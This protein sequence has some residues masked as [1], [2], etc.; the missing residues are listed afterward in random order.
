MTHKKGF[1]CAI[2]TI[3]LLIAVYILCAKNTNKKVANLDSETLKSMTYTEITDDDAKIDNCEFVEFS[4]FFT[5]DLNGDGK[6]E[7][8]NGVCQNIDSSATVYFRLSV[9]SKGYLKNGKISIDGKNFRLDTAIAADDVIAENYIDYDTKQ[10]NFVDKV[11]NGTQKLIESKIK[12]RIENINDYSKSDNSVIF[13]GTYVYQDSNGSDVEIPISKKCNLTVDWYGSLSSSIVTK[14]VIKY[15]NDKIVTNENGNIDLKFTVKTEE[16]SYNRLLLNSN[17]VTVNIPKIK[18]ISASNAI[19][20]NENVSTNYDI[21]SGKLVITRKAVVDENGNITKALPSSNEYEIKMTY[22]GEI[23]NNSA[24]ESIVI[25][26]P[27]QSYYTGF[28]N[29]GEEFKNEI[30]NNIAKSNV[31]EK[32]FAIT[33]ENPIGE[34]YEFDTEVGEYVTYPYDRYVVSKKETMK[35]YNNISP[36]QND[37]YDVRWIFKRGTSGVIKK[38][39]MYATKAD[40]LNSNNS[41]EDYTTN[42]GIYIDGAKSMLNSDGYINIYDAD[43]SGNEALLHS[44]T[45][46]DWDKYT[47]DAP[48]YYEKSVK[49]IRAEISESNQ[50]STLIIHNVKQF[51]NEKLAQKYS[52]QE[53]ESLNL[54]YTNLTGVPYDEN[55]VKLDAETRTEV[56]YYEDEISKARATISRDKISTVET[57]ENEII[58][59][60]TISENYNESKWKNGEFLIEMPT[61]ITLMT[62]NSVKS[63][64]SKVV[65]KGYNLFEK[66]GKYF[67]KI[68]TE[69][70]VPDVYEVYVDC[71]ITPNS[72]LATVTKEL[73]LYA[74]NEYY[75]NYENETKDI[76]DANNNENVEELVGISSDEIQFVAPTGLITYQS[77]TDYNEYGDVTTAPNVAEIAKE[78]RTATVIINTIN[79][80]SNTISSTKI[81]GKIPFEGNKY[82]ITNGNLGS[83]YTANLNSKIVLDLAENNSTE[84]SDEKINE[85]KNNI[86]IYYST[87]EVTNNNLQDSSNGWTLESDVKD[88]SSVKTYLIDFGNFVMDK[89]DVISFKYEIFVPEGIAYEKTTYSAYAVYFNL[90]TPDGKLADYTEPNKLGIK[91]TRKYNLT[92]T[93]NKLGTSKAVQ[94]AL[95][96]LEYGNKNDVNYESRI[97]LTD[98]NGQINFENLDV[99]KTYKLSELKCT[100][101]YE[102]S[103]GVFEFKVVEN[104]QNGKLELSALSDGAGYNS[105]SINAN[106]VNINVQDKIKFKL[107]LTKFRLGTSTKVAGASYIIKSEIGDEELNKTTNS[108]GS[109]DIS[110]LTLDKTYIIEEISASDNFALAQGNLKFVVSQSAE[111]GELSVKILESGA[112]YKTYTINQ[113]DEK[114]SIQLE[115]EIRYKIV[116]NKKDSNSNANLVGVKYQ[117]KGKNVDTSALTDENGNIEFSKLDLGE[118]YIVT[119]VSAKDYYINEPFEVSVTKDV[120]GNLKSNIGTITDN[121]TE[122]VLNINATDTKIPTY[123]LT[124]VKVER[125]NKNKKLSGVTFVVKG[126]NLNEEVT[127]NEEGKVTINGLYEHISEKN[128][129]GTYIIQEKVTADGYILTSDIL[130]I[131]VNRSDN[132][133][134]A[135]ILEGENLISDADNGKD[136]V[137]DNNEITL[138]LENIPTFKVKK[139]DSET[140]NPIA[141]TK[142]AIYKINY[143]DDGTQ[144][145]VEEA[146]DGNGNVIGDE[147]TINNIKYHIIKTNDLGEAT[148]NLPAGYYYIEEIETAEGY[149]LPEGN[150]KIHYFGIGESKQKRA[151]FTTDETEKFNTYYSYIN[152]VE[153][154]DDGYIVVGEAQDKFD[155]TLYDGTTKTL[156]GGFIIKYDKTGK[157]IL[158]CD[159]QNIGLLTNLII[160]DNGDILIT[161]FN[162][163]FI[164]LKYSKNGQL[165]LK[166]TDTEIF[167]DDFDFSSISSLSIT[168]RII[169]TENG[170]KLSG[171]I[172]KDSDSDIV[173]IYTINQGEK[174]ISNGKFIAEYNND[175][176]LLNFYGENDDEYNTEYNIYKRGSVKKDSYT[177]TEYD[178]TAKTI[179]TESQGSMQ[180]QY[181]TVYSLDD[182]GNYKWAYTVNNENIRFCDSI[183]ISDGSVITSGV[184]E[185]DTTVVLNGEQYDLKVGGILL[186]FNELGVLQKIEKGYPSVHCRQLIKNSEG[187]YTAVGFVNEDGKYKGIMQFIGIKLYNPDLPE[188]QQITIN[189]SITKYKITTEVVEGNGTVSG[190]NDNPYEVVRYK[191]NSK[192][193][194]KAIPDSNWKVKRIK[195]NGESI[196]YTVSD[197]GSVTLPQFINMTEDKHIQV[198]FQKIDD[199]YNFEL[200][201]TSESGELLANAK[202]TIKKV[203]KLS[204]GSETLQD[205]KDVDGDFVGYNYSINDEVYKVVESNNDGIIKVN[206]ENGDYRLIEIEAPAN[207]EKSDKSYDFSINNTSDESTVTKLNVANAK[208]QYKITTE[209]LKNSEG[210]R[211]GGTITGLTYLDSVKLVEKVKYGEDGNTNINI[212]PLNGYVIEK[213]YIDGQE[214]SANLDE[215]GC[216]VLDKFKNVTQDHIVQAIF[217]KKY[218]LKLTK[219]DQ[220]G[221]VLQGAKFTIQKITEKDGASIKENAID[222]N[223]NLVGVLENINGENLYVLTTNENG[224]ITAD[225]PNG[226]YIAKEVK[227]PDGY[228]LDDKE[229]SFTIKG[230]VLEL[231]EQYEVTRQ[232]GYSRPGSI[233]WYSPKILRNNKKID[234]SGTTLT[235]YGENESKLWSNNLKKECTGSCEFNGIEENNKSELLIFGYYSGKLTID[236]DLVEN[237]TDDIIL[238]SGST[239][240]A[241]SIIIK[242]NSDGKIIKYFEIGKVTSNDQKNGVYSNGI[243]VQNDGSYVIRL[244]LY[245]NYGNNGCFDGKMIFSSNE[246]FY[247]NEIEENLTDKGEIMIHFTEDDKVININTFPLRVGGILPYK[248]IANGTD[249][250]GVSSVENQITK[251]DKNGNDT[252]ISL[253]MPS[254]FTESRT[255][256]TDDGNYI[257]FGRIYS[258]NEEGKTVISGE[259]TESGKRIIVYSSNNSPDPAVIIYN[260]NGK[261]VNVYT[262]ECNNWGFFTYG[263]NLPNGN[264][265]AIGAQNNGINVTKDKGEDGYTYSSTES[266]KIIVEFASDGKIVNVSTTDMQGSIT[267]GIIVYGIYTVDNK[268]VM[269]TPNLTEYIYNTTNKNQV[270]PIE[271]QVENTK[272]GN[273]IVHHYLKTVDGLL[274]TTR[275]ADD[276][277]I[278]DA[279]GKEYKTSPKKDLKKVELQKNDNGE[280]IIPTNMNGTISKDTTEVIYYYE[281]K[282]IELTIHHYLDGTQT[283]IADDRKYTFNPK[284]VLNDDNTYKII[285][286][287]TYDVDTNEEYNNLINDYILTSI[288]SDVKD[289]T[290]LNDILTF[291]EDKELTFYYKIKQHNITTKVEKHTEIR[292]DKL[293]NEKS[294]M[295]VAGGTITGEYNDT[296]KKE[297]EIQFVESVK[298]KQ[299]ST[300]SII[301]KPDENY[302]VKQIKLQSIT[303]DGKLSE[304]I[305]YG[306]GA[307]ENPE[308]T[309]NYGADK[310]VALSVFKSVTQNKHIIV[311]FEPAKSTVII[312]HIIKGQ[313]KD[314]KT[315]TKTDLIGE[316]YVSSQ[317]NITGYELVS[318]SDNASGKYT[319]DVINVYYTYDKSTFQYTVHYFYDGIEDESKVESNNAKYQ[320]KITA[321][322]DKNKTGYKFEKTENIPLIITEVTE[323]NVINVYYVK[324]EFS[325]TVEYYYENKTSHQY[326]KD[327]KASVVKSAQYS[328]KITSYVDK[329]KKGY[330]LDKVE[331]LPLTITEIAE[332]NII[333]IYYKLADYNYIIHYFYNGVEDT[334]AVETK[335]AKYQD[336]ITT[337]PDKIK[338]GF[339]L[340]KTE[341]LPLTITE[342]EESNV[343]NIYYKSEFKITTDVIEHTEKYK[344]GIIKENVKGGTITG[345]DLDPYEKVLKGNMPQNII[346]IVPEKELDNDGN[347]IGEYEI[348]NVIIKNGKSAEEQTKLDV[349]SLVQSDGSM[350]VPIQYIADTKTGMQSDKHIEV[351]FR[352]KT[353]VIVK[354]L[355]EETEKVLYTT[356]DG[357]D[358]EEQFGVEGESYVTSRKIIANYKSSSL[359]VTNDKK[360]QIGSTGTM[361][362]DT[363]TII[364]W[365]EKIPAGIIVKHI[366]IDEN[367]IKQGLTLD[368]GTVLNEELIAGYVGLNENIKRA[369]YENYISVNGP[370]SNDENIVIATKDEDLKNVIYKENQSVEVRY[371]Y[372]RQYKVT[373][374]IKQHKELVNGNEVLVDGGTISK[375]YIQDEQGNKKEIEYEL[376]NKN[377]YNKKKIE[378]IPDDGYRVKEVTI[379]DKTYTAKQLQE[380]EKHIIIL[381]AGTDELEDDAYFKNVQED[382]KVIVEFEKIPAKVVV[383]Y[384][385]IDTKENLLPNKELEGYVNDEYNEPKQEIENYKLTDPEPTNNKGKMTENQITVTYWYKKQFK[386]TTD[387]IEHK[388]VTHKLIELPKVGQQETEIITVKGGSIS[389]E[390]ETPYELVDRG[391]TTQ[392]KI[393]LKPED[394]YKIVGIKING[395]GYEIQRDGETEIEPIKDVQEDKHIEVQYERAKTTLTVKYLKQETNKELANEE[396]VSAN[397][398]EKYITYAKKINDYELVEKPENSEGILDKEDG[399]VVIYYYRKKVQIEE[400]KDDNKQDTNKNEENEVK[401]DQNSDKTIPQP[402]ET[403][404]TTVKTGDKILLYF[405]ILAIS[406]IVVLTIVKHKNNEK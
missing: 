107:N 309:V 79:N 397:I 331:N 329:T 74:Y 372:E 21:N 237:A 219:K 275:V 378:I 328:E 335:V 211:T 255:T 140:N 384:K 137:S 101:D 35:V 355:E 52:K 66:D 28:N 114:V 76:Y 330:V 256:M 337:Y 19:V 105:S 252:D 232:F 225:L 164:I 295:I 223:G 62:I 205:A 381:K 7:K 139:V 358:Y 394:G 32:S 40:E 228:Y 133:L 55:S 189:N 318:V 85:L 380:Q 332:N 122:V 46:S 29:P 288:S 179:T 305:I 160:A 99:E 18:G 64:N 334:E 393:L 169:K 269:V 215:N 14:D 356:P 17:I 379:N 316:P 83:E 346:K 97:E 53:F 49:N 89:G 375:E 254:G 371:Y 203:T 302:V 258:D 402:I 333:K 272:M 389:G 156:V 72:K 1:F 176:E 339:A 103:T 25:T 405:A 340:E 313:D 396:N 222:K 247:G 217:E 284:T 246:T 321:Y 43:K 154:V 41:L 300:V 70:D 243:Y 150:D 159:S 401:N 283:K 348:V 113:S 123:N 63:N 311:E 214:F 158:W 266:S 124:I 350:T 263:I 157:K 104:S 81:L 190:Q 151:E 241:R 181:S 82:V 92:L 167:G 65:I 56:A 224:I 229:E 383:E 279:I 352:K 385:D 27:V 2:L 22:P 267:Q 75:T 290:T 67:I 338:S 24:K 60:Q 262:I 88:W 357:K 50:N 13:T 165:L 34:V 347:I 251:Y 298:Q 61:G 177:K 9:L 271:L 36:N 183:T 303:D 306:E 178:I 226:N 336:Y 286:E 15:S 134:N 253:N 206:L 281:P 84:F 58:R 87:N 297:N 270:T 188:L 373:T 199:N 141:N 171:Q 48:F 80:Y 287:G 234:I 369:K 273:V 276:E 230:Q 126:P 238:D 39:E 244:A 161:G 115:D 277:I 11:N 6:A 10:I 106:T 8:V 116:L 368:V 294:E 78:Q 200:T 239:N 117:I 221:N 344:D 299:D 216:A 259:Y 376:I 143:N 98:A 172:T 37:T 260:S 388:E 100:A 301:A 291:N 195:V 16:D 197:D 125:G 315:Q 382:K 285:T 341:N 138:T 327:E 359:G 235:M 153:E 57:T 131:Q 194:I 248:I 212:N 406:V 129:D 71:N 349:E 242:M 128:V 95:Y 91:V 209:I 386:I 245:G 110:N 363:L 293:T 136:I 367:D 304:N 268:V 361:F 314:Y 360:E 250:I 38:T 326:D 257:S 4:S 196:E 187:R 236:K 202:F 93:K 308:I 45:A 198:Y 365:Y 152:D 364:Y 90:D 343:I 149:I 261:I 324:D 400:P 231:K 155:V 312:H 353:K 370:K 278:T 186:Q 354:Y 323:N 220:D 325:Y 240:Y 44:F 145:N 33:Y 51:Y 147:E 182:D 121:K 148:I 296:Y 227:A 264:I 345:E 96:L 398:N 111:N 20:T 142:F 119:E 204:D 274:T 26:V 320:D 73:N 94:N 201:K 174:I 5:R 366:E 342:K 351:E 175:V 30:A 192:N 68:I 193:E 289:V 31:A 207:Y 374:G 168:N 185:K 135:T 317:I 54:I 362:A 210:K 162:T 292:T 144:K 130:K 12:P 180:V 404:I 191:E 166:K 399:T 310:S 377:G 59:I 112:G 127:T 282:A 109:I 47:K 184:V 120:Q 319:N 307:I 173:K 146:K 163:S 69:N 132:K 218:T 23:Y 86:K 208:K 102:L 390:D 280:F 392:K 213:L 249:F 233:T 3:I 77:L 395:V 170:F 42:V 391:A 403:I 322:I 118:K 387:V 265:L 108:D